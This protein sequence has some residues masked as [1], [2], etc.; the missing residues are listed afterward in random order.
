MG[1]AWC[2]FH[3]SPRVR[4]NKIGPIEG[5]AQFGSLCQLD[6]HARSVNHEPPGTDRVFRR[7]QTL[8]YGAEK[9]P[10]LGMKKCTAQ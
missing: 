5:F 7:L 2:V 1:H 9:E 8:P 10:S 3:R 6:R 4:N